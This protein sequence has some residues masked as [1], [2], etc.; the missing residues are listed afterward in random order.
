MTVVIFGLLAWGLQLCYFGPGVPCPPDSML[1][2]KLPPPSSLASRLSPRLALGLTLLA[3]AAYLLTFLLGLPPRWRELAAVCQLPN[4]PPLVLTPADEAALAGLGL[5]LDH[6]AAFLLAIEVLVVALLGLLAGLIVW[7][8][9][10]SGLALLTA[11]ALVAFGIAIVGEADAALARAY[12]VL[13]WP[14]GLL[15]ALA[16][17]P[18]A[19]LLFAFPNGRLVPRWSWLGL[20]IAALG[21]AASLPFGPPLAGDNPVRLAVLL[22][23]LMLIIAGVAA[24]V[25]RYRHVSNALERQQ[26]KWVLLG[27]V[28][29]AA[30]M[31]T[32]MIF[33]ELFPLPAG[34]ARV[35]LALLGTAGLVLLLLALPVSLAFAILRYRLWDIDILIRRTL[36]YAVLT[37]TLALVY[38]G[39]VVGLQALLRLATG[40]EQSEV[41]VVLSTLLIAALFVPVRRRWQEAID[42]RFYR[43]RY[44]AAQVLGQF[45]LGLRD[46]VELDSLVN[47]LVATVDQTMQPESIALLLIEPET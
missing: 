35:L 39:T 9:G 12:P 26:T 18:F 14:V 43:Q 45:G 22:A 10:D 11:V 37:A 28:G 36:V 44:D 47:R 41:V 13:A 6:Y 33:F 19:W 46:E 20:L 16:I 2:A 31:L 4:C 34:P 40:Q 32:Y 24:Q 23:F 8:R 38:F 27:L 5:S 17:L 42:R 15:E 1:S 25:Y 29:V 7:Q 30:A 3:L 21:L